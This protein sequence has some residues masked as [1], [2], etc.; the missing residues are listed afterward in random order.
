MITIRKAAERGHTKIGWLESWH[1]FSFGDY[2]DPRH[3]HFGP[4]RVINEDVVAPAAGFPTHPHRDMEIVTW[5][6][7]GALAHRDSTGNS[8][9]LRPGE[10][11]RMTAGTGIT[12]SE[13]NASQE[14]PVH[15]LQIWLL[16]EAQ[17]L[18][19]GYEQKSFAGEYENRLRL[20]AARD[21]REGAVGIHQNADIYAA[22]LEAGGRLAHQP[23]PGRGQWI[24]VARGAIEV[25]GTA[26]GKG[27]G[28]AI[29]D[30]AAL[31]I[32]AQQNAEFLL[33]DMA[34]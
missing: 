19:P 7:S 31:A 21:A 11:Q 28:A 27:D 25:N 26:L 12:H 10:M 6:L 22:R 29:A 34:A 4:L 14:E 20:V 16:P 23:A 3:V 9:V 15:L 13:F 30:E 8:E 18:K 1:S 5:V 24:Q 33:F 32:V 17:N 2:R